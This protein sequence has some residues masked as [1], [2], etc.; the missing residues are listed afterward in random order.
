MSISRTA[1]NA[2]G[3]QALNFDGPKSEGVRQFFCENARYWIEE[4]HFDGLRLDATQAIFDSSPRHVIADIVQAA[5]VAGAA[6]NKRVFVVAE[7]RAA[8]RQARALSR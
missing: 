4:F 8:T 3:G 1:T 6:L 5:R 7:I 2:S